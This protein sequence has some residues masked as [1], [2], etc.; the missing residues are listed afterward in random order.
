MSNLCRSYIAPVLPLSFHCRNPCTTLEFE[1]KFLR[2]QL[3]TVQSVGQSSDVM[4][5]LLVLVLFPL[6]A[7]CDRFMRDDC[8][9]RNST[10]LAYQRHLQLEASN[11]PQTGPSVITEWC[12][13]ATKDGRGKCSDQHTKQYNICASHR[14]FTHL[15]RSNEFCYS[16]HGNHRGFKPATYFSKGPDKIC[17]SYPLA[18][19]HPYM[20]K[21]SLCKL[22]RR[23][24]HVY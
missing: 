2:L 22:I 8:W 4:L 13:E 18:F 10:H 15:S 16:N 17:E 1:P 24:D 20:P 6:L 23:A 3:H 19:R 7:L 12:I 21:S 5:R 9:C 11:V 14:A